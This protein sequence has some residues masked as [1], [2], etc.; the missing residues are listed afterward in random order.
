MA[1]TGKKRLFAEALLAGKSNKMAALAAGYSAASASAAGSRLAKDKDV[2]AH[3]QR[4][5]KVVSA[6]PPAAAG[7]EPTTGSFDLSQA[8]S[9]KDPRAFLLAAMNDGQLEPKLRIDAAKA[10]MPFEFAKKGEGGK[11][12]EK[13]AAAKKVASRFSPASP[14]KLVLAHGRPIS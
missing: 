1:L 13:A 14:P 9:H 7:A 3:L 8:L 2:L 5:A 12:E 6:A 10:L 11:K 4:K